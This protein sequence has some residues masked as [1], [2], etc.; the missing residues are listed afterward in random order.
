MREFNI[1]G[2]KFSSYWSMLIIAS[3]L[4]VILSLFRAKKYKFGKTKAFIIAVLLLFFGC[5]GTKLLY[6]LEHPENSFSLRGGMSLFGS[7]YLVPLAFLAAAPMIKEN[8][9][10]CMDFTAMYDPLIFAC[11]R[12]GCYLNKC[13]GGMEI[14]FLP[15]VQLMEAVFDTAIFVFLFF[16]ERNKKD[17]IYGKQYPIFMICY[18]F[19]RFFLEFIRNTEKNIFCL[20]EGQWL[21]MAAFI[22]GFITLYFIKR[23]E[24]LK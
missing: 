18:S 13:C 17:N 11:M 15:P 20:S 23:N 10:K 12:I 3:V 22:I 8:Y 19:V 6:M 9:L 1:F 2:Y 21:S 16:Y 14:P 5:L 7:V 4:T 24:V